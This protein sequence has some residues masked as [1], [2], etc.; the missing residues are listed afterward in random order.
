MR[1]IKLLY[2][3]ADYSKY[4][5]NY[6]EYFKYELAKLP[7]VEL[8][9]TTKKHGLLH[10]MRRRSFIPD[11][12][13]IDGVD[14]YWQN[15]R[16][17]RYKLP[18]GLED[19]TIPKGIILYDIHRPFASKSLF[20]AFIEINKINLIFSPHRDAFLHRFPELA[21]KLRWLPSHAY[22]PVFHSYKQRKTI[23]FLFM[24]D[25]D[26]EV[27]PLRR[28]IIDSMKDLPG[29]V[30][31]LHPGYKNF[32]SSPRALIRKKYAK[33]I[34]KARMFL[35][36]ASV[37]KYP[38]AKYFEV[39]ACRTLLLAEGLPELEE[40]GFIDGQT[41]VQIN[42]TNFME[43]ADFYLKNEKARREITRNGYKLIQ[44]RHTTEIRA[45]QFV[46][47]LTAYLYS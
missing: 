2:C 41:F 4:S 38:I 15:N 47:Y 43:K 29:F 23:D 46:N 32:S 42:S 39:P 36:D 1:P 20:L 21:S 3:T 7:Q 28:K 8:E 31:H 12:I 33:E 14:F 10:V 16:D 34:N 6:F 9:F 44:R 11:F 35:T 30:H 45:K 24:G 37:F 22:T 40:L 26:P 19:T 17:I 13:F 27:Y 25:T 5:F 18:D